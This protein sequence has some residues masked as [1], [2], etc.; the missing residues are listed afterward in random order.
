MEPTINE[1]WD[2]YRGNI[3]DGMLTFLSES[4]GI[5][6][7][8]LNMIGVGWKLEDEAWVFP[9]RN[10]S[11]EVI[12]LVRRFRDG[13]KR[14]ET[15]H[16]RGLT[17]C[18]DP[19]AEG[20]RPS[21]QRWIRVTTHNP[22][23]ICGHTKWCTLDGNADNP[24]F[25]RCMKVREGSVYTDRQG[26]HFHEIV[27]GSF[28]PMAQT[29]RLLP[30]SA[31]PV[32]VVE[33]P[34]DVAAAIDLGFVAVGKPSALG[35]N[36][37]LPILLDGRNVVVLGENDAEAGQKGMEST[38]VAIQ[39]R[40]SRTRMLMPP[41][42]IKDLRGWVQA[43]LTHDELMLAID[44]KGST[45]PDARVL[46]DDAPFIVARRVL[47]DH[48]VDDDQRQILWNWTDD[49][50]AFDGKGYAPKNISSLKS[51]LYRIL[52]EYQVA[53][54]T[55]RGASL[56]PFKPTIY[57]LREVMEAMQ[58]HGHVEGEIPCW[59]CDDKTMLPAPE[60]LIVFSNGILDMQ[61]FLRGRVDLYPLTPNLFHMSTLPYSFDSEAK[62]PTWDWFVNNVFNGD[63]ERKALLQEWM[64]YNLSL[65]GPYQ[66]FMLMIGRTASGKS[67]IL[68]VLE[69]LV[70][71]Q[72]ADVT[73]SDLGSQFG[74]SLLIGKRTIILP[75]AHIT[76]STDSLAA[77]EFLKSVVGGDSISVD[78]K[79]RDPICVKLS[80]KITIS[81]NELP[82]LPD[83][84]RTLERRLLMLQLTN[85]YVGREDWTLPSRLTREIEG[86]CQWAL[87]GLM[88]LQKQGRFTEPSFN[89]ELMGD[90]RQSLST[91]A[92][93]I[94]SCC[95]VLAHTWV[96][97]KDLFETWRIW[98]K[99]H[100]E[101][102]G[103]RMTLYRRVLAQCPT[104][105]IKHKK[106]DGQGKR[107][108]DGITLNE[109]ARRRYMAQ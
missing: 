60:N 36:K 79:Y 107:V 16:K 7:Q 84:A 38:F 5:S 13:L 19:T 61:Q 54:Q 65:H 8:A 30:M 86:I 2:I 102:A 31:D 12:G 29:A 87:R 22:C 15:G 69:T 39:N 73:F 48:Y 1:L 20:Y 78:R 93:F 94:G 3:T 35:G 72:Q 58:G 64:G 42:H 34:T 27:P 89:V 106:L 51:E 25:V 14:S 80:G 63:E 17:F 98:R 109:R 83:Q 28:K 68:R 97:R 62:C 43:G 81:A 74:R 100:G 56:E 52:S 53:K 57:K 91:V 77:L 47:D 88:R 33:G 24:R 46:K 85:S 95:R 66:K 75:D 76:R 82:E 37:M 101:R 40:C 45:E 99:E 108:F 55:Q 21:R 59:L 50:Y 9:E 26:G 92:E 4:L 41:P 71:G 11:G 23:P 49:W 67:T 105:E 103:S 18:P 44:A 32:L 90:Y 96:E 10:T 6:V 104:V 70:G